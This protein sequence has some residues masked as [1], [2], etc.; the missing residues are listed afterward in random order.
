M[1]L[2]AEEVLRGLLPAEVIAALED[3]GAE[4]V[5]AILIRGLPLP[6]RLPPTPVF[7]GVV[8]DGD[9]ALL[10]LTTLGLLSIARIRPVAYRYENHGRIFRNVLALEHARGQKSSQGDAELAPH[11]DNFRGNFEHEV[12]GAPR[13]LMPKVLAFQ[14]VRNEDE[15]GNA[16]PTN[17][18][19]V[20][21]ILD[22]LDAATCA[23]LQKEEFTLKPVASNLGLERNSV[24]LLSATVPARAPHRYLRYNGTSGQIVPETAGAK[25]ALEA[26]DRAVIAAAKEHTI[27]VNVGAGDFFAFGNYVNLHSRPA[28]VPSPYPERARW[29]RRIFGTQNLDA[30]AFVDRERAPFLLE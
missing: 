8:D 9:L 22:R 28:F 14:G 7:T 24:A 19:P 5:G 18:L 23:A 21:A 29:L 12:I 20:A 13:S 1:Q 6:D 25:L 10:D 16:V 17:L 4:R 27:P 26:L 15:N 3:F 30:G 11:A 2:I